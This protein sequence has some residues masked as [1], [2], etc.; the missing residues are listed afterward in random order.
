MAE[1]YVIVYRHVEH[2]LVAEV[3]QGDRKTLEDRMTALAVLLPEQE[4]LACQP[5]FSYRNT[6]KGVV[7]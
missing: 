4:I 7:Q 6:P 2:G 5:I 3:I 1:S